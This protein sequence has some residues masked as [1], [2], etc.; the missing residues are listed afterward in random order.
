[1]TEYIEREVLD[2]ALTVAAAADSDKRRRAWVEAIGIVHDI[3]AADVAPVAHAEWVFDE[4]GFAH[5]SQCGY[6]QDFPRY[7][8]HYCP[9]CGAKC[10]DG[11]KL[12]TCWEDDKRWAR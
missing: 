2:K 3:P 12:E 7:T 10:E 6:E 9:E 4:D 5:C 1:M 8:S 11:A